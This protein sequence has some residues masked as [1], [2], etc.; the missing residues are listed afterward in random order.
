MYLNKS[1]FVAFQADAC[2]PLYCEVFQYFITRGVIK[3]QIC[4]KLKLVCKL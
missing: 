1:L 4:F 2:F 3:I